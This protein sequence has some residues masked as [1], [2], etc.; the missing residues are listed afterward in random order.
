MSVMSLPNW[1]PCSRLKGTRTDAEIS[2]GGVHQ[3]AHLGAKS[4]FVA[5]N[6]ED[7]KGNMGS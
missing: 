6:V 5:Q 2:I 1:D 7:N 4:K 3:L